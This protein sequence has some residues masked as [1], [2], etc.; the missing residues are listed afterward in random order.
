MRGSICR[1]QD[2]DPE[3]KKTR[4]LATTS[5]LDDTRFDMQDQL[6]R[7]S[8]WFRAR[9]AVAICLR[10]AVQ[11]TATASRQTETD[12]QLLTLK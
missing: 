3:V 8:S 2:D 6:A 11:A 12:R 9:R 10:P 4:V 5:R 7:F 1:V